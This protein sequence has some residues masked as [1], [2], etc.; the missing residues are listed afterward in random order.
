MKMADL[1]ASEGYLDAGYDIISLDDCWLAHNRS[2]EGK[3]QP[4][5]KRFPSGIKRL[6]DYVRQQVNESALIILMI[7]LWVTQGSCQGITVW[8]LRRL[9][10]PNLRRLSWS[11]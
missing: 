5:A 10:H 1:M 4:D 6:A 8:Y 7:L 3:L 11:D 9:R 2:E